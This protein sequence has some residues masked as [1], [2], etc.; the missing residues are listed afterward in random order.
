MFSVSIAMATYNGSRYIR[1]QLASLAAQSCLPTE[2]VITDDCSND[3]TLE[4]ASDFA[5]AAPFPMRLYRNPTRLGYRANFMRAA[6]LCN[7][8]LIAF[9]DQD[10]VWYPHKIKNCAECFHNP[11]V[12]LTYHNADVTTGSGPPIGKLDAHAAPQLLNPPMSM[13]P[14]LFGLGFTLMFRRSLPPL[15]DLWMRSVDHILHQRLGHDQWFFFLASVLGTVA[16]LD[17]P[18]AAYR[19]HGVNAY[20]WIGEVKTLTL[21]H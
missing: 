19:Q 2:L 11:D 21:E 14:W 16:Y 18:Q 4:L 5:R 13:N 10:D 7:S 6:S 20:G 15:T 12:L 3:G 8:D 17:E 9:C 1:E